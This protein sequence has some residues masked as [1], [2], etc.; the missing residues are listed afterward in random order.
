M[1]ADFLGNDKPLQ[2]YRFL[3]DGKKY[4][5]LAIELPVYRRSGVLMNE[6]LTAKNLANLKF[7]TISLKNLPGLAVDMLVFQVKEGNNSSLSI[8]TIEGTISLLS[9]SLYE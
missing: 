5:K 6:E 3:Y 4:P 9:T 7:G 8:D 1:L 2:P